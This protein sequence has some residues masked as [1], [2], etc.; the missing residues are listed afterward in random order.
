MFDKN[1]DEPPGRIFVLNMQNVVWYISLVINWSWLLWCQD[2]TLKK[3]WI[4]IQSKSLFHAKTVRVVFLTNPLTENF[5]KNMQN[6]DLYVS[7]DVD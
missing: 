2:E 1:V 4:F 6:V 3:G 5:F 7:L